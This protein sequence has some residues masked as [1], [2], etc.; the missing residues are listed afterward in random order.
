VLIGVRL[1]TSLRA[2][3]IYDAEKASRTTNYGM[4]ALF[5]FA[6]P[7]LVA[8]AVIL[9]VRSWRGYGLGFLALTALVLAFWG[10]SVL[11]QATQRHDYE[12]GDWEVI[13]VTSGLVITLALTLGAMYEALHA[14]QRWWLGAIPVVSV[15]PATLILTVPT[16]LKFDALG[17]LGLPMDSL[18]VIAL[19]PPVLVACAYALVRSVRRPIASTS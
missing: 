18:P 2:A 16:R 12:S 8:L 7:A 5:L 1:A 17:A 4:W 15:I 10:Y 14:R 11:P 19:L 3:A 6:T 9:D 13:Y